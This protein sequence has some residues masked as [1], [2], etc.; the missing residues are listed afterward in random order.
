MS[1]ADAVEDAGD[2]DD[3][4]VSENEAE[5]QSAASGAGGVGGRAAAIATMEA[6]I[7]QLHTEKLAAAEAEE[8]GLAK[9]LKGKIVELEA[10]LEELRSAPEA[11]DGNAAAVAEIEAQIAQLHTEKLAAAEKEE[12]GLAKEL[13]GKIVELEAKLGELRSGGGAAAAAPASA[14]AV[15]PA[16]ATSGA[17]AA[18][19][20]D[21]GPA[22]EPSAS[23]SNVAVAFTAEGS[24]GIKFG[25][26]ADGSG[27]LVLSVNAGGQAIGHVLEGD[28]L[29]VQGM[30]AS[31]Y[32]KKMLLLLL[33]LVLRPLSC[34]T[35]TTILL[36]YY[37]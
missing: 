12:Y 15:A 26:T 31:R 13:K 14:A 8:Y 37:Y 5:Q 24:L 20:A 10:G 1:P 33:L 3:D 29:I 22:L 25:K 28:Q 16:P 35:P 34:R 36:L 17:A 19:E 32:V 6:Q 30:C 9:E 27:L 23:R 21:E 18:K 2:D 7:E 11:D 4:M